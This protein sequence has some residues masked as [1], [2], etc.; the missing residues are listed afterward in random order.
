MFPEFESFYKCIEYASNLITLVRKH[1]NF[2]RTSFEEGIDEY[3][4]TLYEIDLVY[5][6]FIWNYRRTNQNKILADLVQKVEKVYS[7]DWLL[8]YNNEW[9]GVIDNLDSWS[10]DSRLSQKNFFNNHVKPVVQNNRLFVIISDAF[11]YE[12]GVELTKRLQS[13]NRYEASLQHMVAS[14][15]SYT[16]LGMASLLPH[17]EL[18]IPENNDIVFCDGMSSAGTQGRTKICLLY[19]SD[20]ADE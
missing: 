14:L 2:K 5:R 17:T 13:E 12:C 11:R 20:A 15:P 8:L 18:T 16:Q 19:T 6:K 4:N 7:N 10:T 1:A 9:Q 3:A